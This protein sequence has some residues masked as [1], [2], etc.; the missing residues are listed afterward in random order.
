MAKLSTIEGG[1]DETSHYDLKQYN[2][3]LS[4]L[5]KQVVKLQRNVKIVSNEVKNTVM[6]RGKWYDDAAEDFA[7]WWNNTS[8]EG[9]ADGIDKLNNISTVAE[10][11]TRITAVDV[12]EKMKKS[13][14]LGRSYEKHTYIANFAKGNEYIYDIENIT[15]KSLGEIP[16]TTC[17]PN[18]K[19]M[20]DKQSLSNMI[21]KISSSFDNI[22]EAIDKIRKLVQKNLIEG[23]A[24]KLKGLSPETLKNKTN[25]VKKHMDAICEEL[26][27]ILKNSQEDNNLTDKE[28]KKALSNDFYKSS[29]SSKKKSSTGTATAGAVAGAG[30][31]AGATAGTTSTGG[32]SSSKNGGGSGNKGGTT[33]SNNNGTANSQDKYKE[34]QENKA[35]KNNNGTAN[36]QDKYKEMQNNKKPQNQT[37]STQK[38][39]NYTTGN[40]ESNTT[41]YAP[42]MQAQEMKRKK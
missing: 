42:G 39:P 12:C 13:K 37:S 28:L 41:H 31:T 7:K 6:V 11:L 32:S 22:D 15:K 1:F 20:A 23:D 36:S 10:E 3:Y 17:D 21:N 2:E 33:S 29:S 38:A 8:K 19:F 27:N 16:E 4:D 9:L 14:K 24:L 18:T 26:F 34:M 40:H 35:Q 30:A 5:V 25:N